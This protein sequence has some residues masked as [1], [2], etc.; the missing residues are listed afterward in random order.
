MRGWIVCVG[1]GSSG[2]VW[3]YVG[4]VFFFYI[5]GVGRMVERLVKVFL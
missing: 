1:L 5:V 3:F 4:G 2:L